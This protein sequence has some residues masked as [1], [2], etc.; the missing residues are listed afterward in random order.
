MVVL[1]NAHFSLQQVRE[2]NSNNWAVYT[3]GIQASQLLYDFGATENRIFATNMEISSTQK[4][5]DATKSQIFLEIISAFYEVQRSLLQSR[6]ARENLQS[7]KTFVNF[8]RERN[9]LGASSS[10]D[11]VRAESRVAGALNLLASSLQDLKRSQAVYRQYFNEE[12]E[13]YVL[14][15]NYL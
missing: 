11:V 10:A 9:Q 4:Q 2:G 12:A 5:I 7:R 15:K 6:L 14:P 13:P 3:A 1:V 8:I